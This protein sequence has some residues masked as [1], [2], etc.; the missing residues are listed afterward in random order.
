MARDTNDLLRQ[1][2][3]DAAPVRRLPR[4]WV[5]TA[6]WL[7]LALPYI[8]LVVFLMSP[9]SDLAA[10]MA[11]PRFLIQELAALAVAIVAAAA[12]F[13]SVI[14]AYG[15]K[16]LVWLLVPFGFWLG[17][18]G[19]GCLQEWIQFGSR[20]LSLG[21]DW[22][23]FPGIVLAGAG[24][25][26]T[27]AVMLRRGAPLTP[28]LTM[29]LGGLAAGALGDFALRLVHHQDAGVMVL[30]SHV[31]AVVVLC[32]LAGGAGRSVLNWRSIAAGLHGAAL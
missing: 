15:R 18:L 16:W 19:Q 1:L 32:G 10:R 20:S 21:T 17:S 13:G 12:A 25:V 8:A 6:A 22:S 23:C 26:I 24:P 2:A 29:A 14:P 30:V 3:A 11:D 5:R 9:R 27:M 7:A 31:G 28:M 4:P